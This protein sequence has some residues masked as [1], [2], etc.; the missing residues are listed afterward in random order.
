LRRVGMPGNEIFP[1]LDTV[2]VREDPSKAE[3]AA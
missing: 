1:V 2:I 3:A